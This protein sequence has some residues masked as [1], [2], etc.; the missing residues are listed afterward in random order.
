MPAHVNLGGTYNDVGRFLEA[1]E[2]LKKSIAL[3]P[4]YAGYTDLGTSY[5][6][7]HKMVPRRRKLT[8]RLSNLIP[9][10]MLPGET[11]RPHRSIPALNSKRWLPTARP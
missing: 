7:L 6:G 1:L 11:W 4:S 2:P 9:N 10:N 8:N 5:M 3:G